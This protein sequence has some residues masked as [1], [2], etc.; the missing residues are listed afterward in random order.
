MPFVSRCVSASHVQLAV[1]E[2]PLEAR[3]E[4]DASERGDECERGDVEEGLPPFCLAALNCYNCHTLSLSLLSFN[5]HY[6]KSLSPLLRANEG[7]S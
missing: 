4:R 6:A 2:S 7:A 5:R 1:V 3:T